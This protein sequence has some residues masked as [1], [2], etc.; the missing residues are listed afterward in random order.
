MLLTLARYCIRISVTSPTNI[1]TSGW[2]SGA[3]R[4]CQWAYP[5]EKFGKELVRLGER[6]EV[7]GVLDEREPLGWR[8]DVGEVLLGQGGQGHYIALA[9]KDEER[10]LEAGAQL[11][12]V[13]GHDLLE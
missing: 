12:G 11:L 9:L 5:A 10:D 8:L 4:V 3:G 13:V 6:G 1:R 2:R 7:S